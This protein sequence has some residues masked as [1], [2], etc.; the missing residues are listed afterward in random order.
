VNL[1]RVVFYWS[2][3]VSAINTDK[4]ALLSVTDARSLFRYD[5]S[6]GDIYW[7]VVNGLMHPSGLAGCVHTHKRNNKT[8]RFIKV[9]GIKYKAHRIAWLI[10]HGCWPPGIIDHIDGDGLNN[11]I[12]NLRVVSHS[13]NCD[14]RRPRGPNRKRSER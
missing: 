9:R 11:R 8:Y 5:H 2:L 12:S 14:N 4:E 13:E 1:D 10:V 6:T 7:I 3:I